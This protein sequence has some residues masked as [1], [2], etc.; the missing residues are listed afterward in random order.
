MI[1]I[2][3]MEAPETI[4]GWQKSQFKSRGTITFFWNF[5]S[6]N[7]SHFDKNSG[8]RI[9]KFRNGFWKFQNA[10]AYQSIKVCAGV[11]SQVHSDETR[12]ISG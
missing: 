10:G 5:R 4:M 12:P 8:N 9:L 6:L 3:K 1:K 11:L 2:K 7:M